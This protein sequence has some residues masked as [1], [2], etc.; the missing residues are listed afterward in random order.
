L[1]ISHSCPAQA[2]AATGD[3]ARAALG[4]DRVCEAVVA[5]VR[6][7]CGPGH[8]AKDDRLRY[9]A[10]GALLNLAFSSGRNRDALAAQDVLAAVADCAAASDDDLDMQRLCCRAFWILATPPDKADA[11]AAP[12]AP[13]PDDKLAV[14]PRAMLRYGEDQQLQHFAC[15][16]VINLAATSPAVRRALG[17]V[18]A[19]RAVAACLKRFP[20]DA[21]VQEYGCRAAVDLRAGKEC[22]IPNFKGSSLGR[23]PL[24]SADFFARAIISRSALEACMLFY[25]TRARGTLTLL[26]L[27]VPAQVYLA[28]GDSENKDLFHRFG[29]RNVAAATQALFATTPG[30]SA[31]ADRLQREL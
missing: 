20:R 1:G 22:D 4:A 5:V 23:F 7:M 10:V 8:Q 26:N 18:D 25:G 24:V 9:Y 30:V 12:R 21:R 3:G 15:G 29:V 2:L 14:V 13:L 6:D 28:R 11:G 16:A 17:R 27:S 19:C 31:W